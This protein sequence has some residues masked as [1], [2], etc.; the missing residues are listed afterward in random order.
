MEIENPGLRRVIDRL[1]KKLSEWS[2][3]LDH[4]KTAEE[5]GKATRMKR[6]YENALLELED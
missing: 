6:L 2:D 1:T 3:K 4:A 5:I